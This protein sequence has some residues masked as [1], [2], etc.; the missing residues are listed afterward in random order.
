MGADFKPPIC[1]LKLTNFSIWQLF[2]SRIFVRYKQ[3]KFQSYSR[4]TG[5]SKALISVS[6][7]VS[8]TLRFRLVEQHTTTVL[9]FQLPV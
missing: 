5:S 7:S 8:Q 6:E 1:P 3:A 2:R 9:H 4:T